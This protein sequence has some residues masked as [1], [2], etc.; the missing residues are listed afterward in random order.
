MRSEQLHQTVV[1]LVNPKP[2]T[3]TISLL[4]GSPAISKVSHATDPPP[5]KVTASVHGHGA[6]RTLAYNIRRRP[7]QSVEFVEVAGGARKSIGTVSGGRGSLR[8]SPAPGSDLRHVEAQFT[9]AGIRAET[10]T[11]ASFRPPSA[12]LARPRHLVA[13]RRGTTLRVSWRRV[14]GATGYELVT[15]S[16]SAR[17]RVVRVRG[18]RASVRRVALTTAGRVTVRATATLRRGAPASARFR[19][20]RRLHTRFR[21][22]P[23][24]PRGVRLG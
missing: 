6:R 15:T 14:A 17:Q 23:R 11:V 7:G 10:R 21:R 16:P 19:A 13:R 3:Y 22:L 12:R 5:A 20:T 2:G 4:P 18:A 9:L 8:V 24:A 1:G